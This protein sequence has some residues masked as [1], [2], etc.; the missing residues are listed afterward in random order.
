MGLK[1]S[2][3]RKEEAE[4]VAVRNNECDNKTRSEQ[5]VSDLFLFF[6]FLF[7]YLMSISDFFPPKESKESLFKI[8]KSFLKLY[9]HNR[10]FESILGHSDDKV[11]FSAYRNTPS[12]GKYV[13][14]K[15][16]ILVFD[17]VRINIRN[18]YNKLSGS[19]TTPT[20]GAYFFMLN[21][22]TYSNDET[23]LGIYA[24]DELLCTA[25]EA[26]RS[27]MASCAVMTELRKGDI[28]HVKATFLG[29]Y[30]HYSN[31]A[32]FKGQH[33]FVGFLYKPL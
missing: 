13:L 19:F 11:A 32:N 3:V 7:F 1:I 21:M 26:S 28:V 12:T 24:N 29:A 9:K 6:S 14:N 30:L 22:M 4:R 16:S 2:I 8:H 15:G 10:Y 31:N 23:T 17:T 20:H 33:S 18:A 27:G 5:S 25:Y